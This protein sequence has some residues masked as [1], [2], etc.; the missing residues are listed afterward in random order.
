MAIKHIHALMIAA[1]I[2]LVSCVK[3]EKGDPGPQGPAGVT[4]NANVDHIAPFYVTAAMWYTLDTLQWNATVSLPEITQEIVDKG[5]VSVYLKKGDQWWALPYSEHDTYTVYGI[6]LGK[7]LLTHADSH[8]TTPEKPV[9]TLYRV[10][11][12]SSDGKT[13]QQDLSPDINGSLTRIN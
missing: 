5:E 10:V 9:T 7:L 12:T 4:K 8:G 2:I 3:G 6:E 13:V 11:I 1:A